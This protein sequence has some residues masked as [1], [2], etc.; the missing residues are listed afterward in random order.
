MNTYSTFSQ[1]Y[2]NCELDIEVYEENLLY[3][4]TVKIIQLLI[5]TLTILNE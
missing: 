5:I 2:I 1:I 3:I 4:R